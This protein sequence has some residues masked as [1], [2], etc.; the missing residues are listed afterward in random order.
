MEDILR[1]HVL[2]HCIRAYRE[3]KRSFDK[4]AH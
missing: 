2:Q 4:D 3:S 1:L